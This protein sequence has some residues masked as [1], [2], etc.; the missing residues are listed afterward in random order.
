MEAM[1]KLVGYNH[2]YSTTY[3]PHSNGMIERFNSTF[4]PQIAK[5]QDRENNNWNEFLAP[6]VFAY[7]T[8]TH[9]KTGYSPYQLVFGR[10]PRL[11]KDQPAS[12]FTFR[13]PNDYYEQLKKNMKLMHRYAHEN[14][15]NRQN[16]Y[17]KKHY[18]K[19]RHDARYSINDRILI[20]RHGLKNK[21]EPKYSATPRIITRERFMWSETKPNESI[22]RT[23]QTLTTTIY[24]YSYENLPINDP[25]N[26]VNN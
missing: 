11:P 20:R 19:H 9:S 1:A 15:T 23:E 14:M 24:Q 8:G 4:I 21:L 25:I 22:E 13:K 2:T 5:L 10:E 6:V 3:H 7:N 18:D 12:A 16:Q 26:I 17:K